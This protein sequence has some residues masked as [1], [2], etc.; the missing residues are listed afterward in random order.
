MLNDLELRLQH[1]TQVVEREAAHLQQTTERLFTSDLATK[2]EQLDAQPE[3]SE[4]IDAFVSRFA[5]LQDTLGDKLIPAVLKQQAETL[6]SALDN[7]GRAERLGWV[8]NVAEWLEARGLH[9][10][11]VH[12]HIQGIE[13]LTNALMRGQELVPMLIQTQQK[14][15]DFYSTTQTDKTI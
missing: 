12:E 10:Q 4:R 5:R 14:L 9:N 7:L 1:L 6:G 13:Q 8:G 3:L 2:L 15:C 11:M